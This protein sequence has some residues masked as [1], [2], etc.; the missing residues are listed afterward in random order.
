MKNIALNG[1]RLVVLLIALAALL[2]GCLA[3]AEDVVSDYS[4]NLAGYC[5][6]VAALNYTPPPSP[7]LRA[8]RAQRYLVLCRTEGRAVADVEPA[9]ARLLAGPGSRFI[10]AYPSWDEAEAAV[11]WL[12]GR[13]GVLY[14]EHDAE[15][16]ASGA[17]E[18]S[19]L[20]RGAEQLNLAGY[21]LLA[22]R[23]GGGSRTVAVVDSGVSSHSRLEG[24][25]KA[26]G[27]DYV[28]ADEDPTNDLSGH[29]THVAGIIA[30]CTADTP[31][32]LY[33]VRVLNASGGGKMSNVVSA[34]LEAT[35]AGVDVIN[36]SLESSVM[37]AALD[38]AIEAAVSRGTTVV[39]AAGNHAKDTSEVCPAH[40]TAE[41]V[42]VV[43]SV[44]ASGDGYSRASYSNYG[45]S[46]DLYAFGSGINS[47]WKDGDYSVQSGT[48]MA[49][50]HVS[51]VCALI[52]LMEGGLSPQ[53]IERRL[54]GVCKGTAPRVL[55]VSGLVPASEDFSLS[56]L[57]LR[58]GETLRLP[59]A[60]RPATSRA[61]ITWSSRDGAVAAVDGDGLLTAEA[62]GSTWL[63][64]SCMGFE[65]AHIAVT[66]A[67]GPGTAWTLPA[68]LAALGDEALMGSA[69]ERVALP[70][71]VES[72]GDR[73]FADCPALRLLA[74]P[75]S[76]SAIGEAILEGSEQAVILCGADSAALACAQA[77]QLQY[78]V[79]AD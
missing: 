9:P 4:G 45:D 48:S 57:R 6:A 26:L 70:E 78:I 19:F 39:V 15:V 10:L 38:D 62:P 75:D 35:D 58:V 31:V 36:L 53:G 17:E 12:Q 34:V 56:E 16:A 65:D 21:L 13:A 29:G 76:V 41:G 42:V 46:V 7:R 74:L 77:R 47:C 63:D 67:E 32:W 51:G 40:L 61:E 8:A 59:V 3:E 69:C 25:V 1:V 60:A 2:P 11:K 50:A 68:G 79:V 52:G 33:P 22:R 49:A 54:L 20:S 5:R 27:Y 72:I 44:V 43:G 23:Y 18:V 28:D 66:V 71:D 30:D 73:A 55:D 37:S 14:A 24:R 64:A